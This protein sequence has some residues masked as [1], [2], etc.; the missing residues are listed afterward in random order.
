MLSP[1]L[2]TNAGKVRG[3]VVDGVFDFRGLRYGASTAGSARFLPPRRPEAWVGVHEA[4]TW[5]PMSPQMRLREMAPPGRFPPSDLVIESDEPMDEDCLTLNLFTPEVDEGAKLPVMVWLHGGG[6]SQGTANLDL[7]DGG[8]LAR[9]GRV[10]VV[11]VNHRLGLFG[12]L[13]LGD[14]GDDRYATSGNVGLL[15]LVLALEWVRDNI[16]QFGGDPDNVTVF[17]QSG[18]NAKISCLLAMP[19]AKGL[20]H[21]AIL[22]SLGHWVYPNRE[23]QTRRVLKVL[24][25]L[26]LAPSDYGKLH[27]LT[28]EVLRTA[29]GV[30]P[31]GDLDLGP[32]IDGVTLFEQP[33]SLAGV[34]S[35][36]A[37]PTILGCATEETMCFPQFG[38][39]P[40]FEALTDEDVVTRMVPMAGERAKECVDLYRSL[41]PEESPGYLWSKMTTDAI[42]FAQWAIPQA[43]RLLATT[44]NLPVYMYLMNWQSPGFDGFYRAAHCVDLPFVF[45][46][47]DSD[48][49]LGGTS[50]SAHTLGRV[51]STAWAN[52]AH[53]GDPNHNSMPYWPK[54]SPHSR[55]VMCFSAS[56][57]CLKDPKSQELKFWSSVDMRPLSEQIAD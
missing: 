24:D 19:S 33:H 41:Y 54:Y 27:D 15:D 42:Y 12:H 46:N 25:R 6:F 7:F 17:G 51:M 35:S 31:L 13:F 43:E 48:P 40:C 34:Q 55:D 52:F 47:T 56:T 5:G 11:T 57:S 20:I 18:G 23:E 4:A 3:R 39:D 38:G 9:T 50:P 49:V 36:A 10:V 16:E 44:P 53:T 37:V 22:Q 30:N 8:N 21:K 28:A 29:Q 14:I 1:I 2:E 45:N 32:V 26:G